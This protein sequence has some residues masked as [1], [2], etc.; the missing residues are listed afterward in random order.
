MH[1]LSALLTTVP[2]IRARCWAPRTCSACP[3]RRRRQCWCCAT[4]SARS[5]ARRTSP[6][7]WGSSPSRT[8]ASP[9]AASSSSS[10]THPRYWQFK[11]IT[12]ILNYM[13][14]TISHLYSIFDVLP[15]PL[16]TNINRSRRPNKS[17]MNK[18]NGHIIE[19]VSNAS[20]SKHWNI[21]NLLLNNFAVGFV[22]FAWQIARFI[23]TSLHDLGM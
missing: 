4:S 15:F 19:L 13:A 16:F 6:T 14:W 7:S 17:L 23:I 12:S 8:T 21:I 20:Q 9:P 18:L 11:H 1:D 22:D 10:T 5:P 2:C 3:R